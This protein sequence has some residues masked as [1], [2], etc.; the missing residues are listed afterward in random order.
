MRVLLWTLAVAATLL[1]S[2][3]GLLLLLPGLKEGLSFEEWPFYLGGAALLAAAGVAWWYGSGRALRR[4]AVGWVILAPTFA[5]ALLVVG[6]LVLARYRGIQFADSLAI[7]GFRETPIEW[8]GFDGPVGLRLDLELEHAPPPGGALYPPE[9]RMGPSV[10]VPLERASAALTGGSGYFK[11]GAQSRATT[12]L[13]LLKAL[14]FR[15]G[16]SNP[17][18]SQP[19]DPSGRSRVSFELYPGIIDRHHGTDRLCLSDRAPGL[20]A[21]SPGQKPTSGCRRQG[22]RIEVMPRYHDGSDLSALWYLFGGSDLVADLG[23]T[24]TA[25]LR[26]QSRLQRAPQAWIAMQ[27]RLEPDGL[28]DAGYALCPPGADSHTSFSVCYCR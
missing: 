15:D 19:L 13:T 18:W 22:H 9:L 12:R 24:L 3:A 20:P 17:E 11:G 26:A 23:A 4:A 10:E 5:A 1:L 14:L 2:L 16:G 8:P 28:V 27:R 7:V 25:A 21:C 6:N